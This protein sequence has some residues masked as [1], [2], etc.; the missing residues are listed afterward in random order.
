MVNETIDTE[1]DIP[2]E[3]LND[4]KDSFED[5]PADVIEESERN[6]REIEEYLRQNGN[7]FDEGLDYDKD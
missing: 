1:E 7:I 6:A 2:A 3:I 4:I 5:I